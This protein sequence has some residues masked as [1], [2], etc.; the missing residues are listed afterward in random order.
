MGFPCYQ[1]LNV[2]SA[3]DHCMLD[4]SHL[5]NWEWVKVRNKLGLKKTGA[6]IY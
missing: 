6:K 2:F 5:I 4:I 1:G 3:K